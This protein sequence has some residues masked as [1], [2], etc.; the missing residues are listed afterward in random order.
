MT[1]VLVSCDEF[2]TNLEMWLAE[3]A[4]PQLA[5]RWPIRAVE[6]SDTLAS[7]NEHE[8]EC[9]WC[10]IMPYDNQRNRALLL[11]VNPEMAEG[12]SL[13]K[14]GKALGIRP[15]TLINWRN[16]YEDFPP[17]FLDI[18]EGDLIYLP[19]DISAFMESRGLTGR[20]DKAEHRPHLA[21]AFASLCPALSV[22]L[23]L[24]VLLAAS[25]C[26]FV[27]GA[28]TSY[29]SV[30]AEIGLAI[31]EIQAPFSLSLIESSS[32]E[33][34]TW[35][36]AVGVTGIAAMESHEQVV[37]WVRR[38][39]RMF[40]RPGLVA[41]SHSLGALIRLFVEPG[42]SVMDVTPSSGF[43]VDAFSQGGDNPIVLCPNAET[44][45]IAALCS[46]TGSVM[47]RVGDWLSTDFSP[48][49]VRRESAIIGVAPLALTD[50]QT[51]NLDHDIFRRRM[52]RF[53][54]TTNPIDLFV[55]HVTALLPPGGKGFVV[56]PSKWG[57]STKHR[58]TREV[59]VRLN[60]VE[61]LLE[62]P[63]SMVQGNSSSTVLVL[64]RDREI[65]EPISFISSGIVEGETVGP[66]MRDLSEDDIELLHHM[67]N[68]EEL[69]SNFVHPHEDN[70]ILVQSA[71]VAS[72]DFVLE[73]S[74]YFSRNG[75]RLRSKRLSHEESLKGFSSRISETLDEIAALSSLVTAL[76]HKIATSSE[77][78]ITQTFALSDVGCPVKVETVMR[79]ASERWDN[80]RFVDSDVLINLVGVGAGTVV[81]GIDP[82]VEDWTSVARLRVVDTDLMKP[83]YV[84]LWAKS[85]EDELK[86]L[87]P[88]RTRKVLPS[89]SIFE[90]RLPVAPSETQ[91]LASVAVM[92]LTGLREALESVEGRVNE[93]GELVASVIFPPN[94]SD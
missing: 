78:A 47:V 37:V 42:A 75:I 5:A 44:G 83:E 31:N 11:G 53:P 25:R 40:G 48:D 91:D 21:E 45:L 41:G 2:K 3:T 27:D 82:V 81:A 69:A 94:S 55:Q 16:R 68:N 38:H 89:K 6:L 80:E 7:M 54:K 9:D 59:L 58:K 65:G 10:Q 84:L 62:L 34:S 56:V 4:D 20:R 35:L 23:R 67:A 52:P 86:A 43:L 18:V 1:D 85:I 79:R 17:G 14:V 33:I 50:L 36:D 30:L 77:P 46:P 49:L 66:R 13:S 19:R 73:R 60:L 26:V 70:T 29:D 92:N 71:K 93:L 39:Q 57:I 51:K 24:V 88:Q 72:N 63:P 87:V 61:A 8:S 15:T 22:E 74:A 12:V 76:G 64:R 28:T 90:L 32:T